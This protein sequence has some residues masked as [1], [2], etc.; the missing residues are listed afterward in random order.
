MPLFA[1]L[2]FSP[3]NV[4]KRSTRLI[5]RSPRPLTLISSHQLPD[6]RELFV[7]VG[8]SSL[9]FALSFPSPEEDG[10]GYETDHQDYCE[11]CQQGGE[12]ILCDTCPR[13]Y[14]L[15]CLDPELEKAPEGKW[16][17][18]HC[19]SEEVNLLIADEVADQESEDDS[20][21]W[22]M[23]KATQWPSVAFCGPAHLIV[24][25]CLKGYFARN[26]TCLLYC[27]VGDF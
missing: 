8:P 22:L 21:L 17:C 7:C 11:V 27:F 14:H 9:H 20:A 15:V 2:T 10:D 6:S 1:L 13:A 12:I 24:V 25:L 26:S 16:S 5:K 18:P 3:L 19:V 4:F 23:E